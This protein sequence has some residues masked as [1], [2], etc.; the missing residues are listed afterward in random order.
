MVV[1]AIASVPDIPSMCV[2][3]FWPVNESFSFLL[4]V[5]STC[6]NIAWNTGPLT[7]HQFRMAWERYQWNKLQSKSLSSIILTPSREITAALA[8]I[9]FYVPV[10]F[11]R[12][13][14][15]FP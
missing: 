3:S 7:A 2:L 4:A 9:S 1:L 8:T 13:T 5:Q 10:S 6:N 14:V 15:S 12:C 11:Q